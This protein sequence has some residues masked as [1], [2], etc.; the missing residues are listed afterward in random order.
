MASILIVDDAKSIRELVK[1]TLLPEGYDVTLA[2]D[3]LVAKNKVENEKFNLI[4]TDINMPNM[5][6]IALIKAI[7]A[8]PGYEYVP[9]LALTTEKDDEIKAQG[10]EAGASGW[11]I[12]PFDPVKLIE[13]VKKVIR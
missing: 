3:G 11:L 12:K 9:V 10:K 1:L 13:T 7:R 6:G 4:I 8:T 2:E 5:D